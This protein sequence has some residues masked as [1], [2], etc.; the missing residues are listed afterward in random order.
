MIQH[1][2]HKN[3]NAIFSCIGISVVYYLF[4][5]KVMGEVDWI[6][7]KTLIRVLLTLGTCIL[8]FR[9][10]AR[11]RIGW[12]ICG[13]L[14]ISGA[15]VLGVTGKLPVN[16]GFNVDA[17]IILG[18][19]CLLS[20]GVRFRKSRNYA[21]HRRFLVYILFFNITSIIFWN[22]DLKVL[23]SVSDFFTCIFLIYFINLSLVKISFSLKMREIS[24]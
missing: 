18:L 17:R 8:T 16:L 24:C 3:I 9:A 6:N 20:L 13:L 15:I 21:L 22:L 14:S 7:N 1:L 19:F 12:S 11:N 23:S 10:T 4:N 2:A 5:S